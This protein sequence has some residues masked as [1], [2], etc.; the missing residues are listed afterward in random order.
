MAK[1]I[2]LSSGSLLCGS[3]IV[4]NVMPSTISERATFHRVKME[5]SAALSTDHSLDKYL[6]SANAKNGVEITFDVSSI[7]RSVASKYVYEYQTEDRTYPYLIYTI[8]AYDEYMIDGILYEREGEYDY[9]SRLYALMGEFTDIERYL[10]NNTKSVQRF[11]RK[12]NIGEVC[13][14]NELLLYPTALSE[15][16]VMGSVITTGQ[17]VIARSLSGLLGPNTFDG[18]TIYVIPP[19]DS[20]MQFQF[21]NKL[22]IV[23]SISADMRKSLSYETTTETDTVSAP[24]GF[25]PNRRI[26]SRKGANQQS[27]EMTSG[28]VNQD[29][30]DWWINEFLDC[31]RGA[32]VR[33]DDFW[34]PCEVIPA[35]TTKIINEENNELCSVDF[36]ARLALSGGFRNRL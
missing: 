2:V 19:S 25:N 20:R 1:S 14:T 11:S 23:E 13:A 16:A 4:F 35:E 5:I 8:K 34:I 17:V 3:P 21:V 6:Q 26:L 36:T 32:W 28:V 22:G 10:S 27:Y 9:G 30:A 24:S 15:P 7:L 29:W 18:H 12:P 33:L 31:K